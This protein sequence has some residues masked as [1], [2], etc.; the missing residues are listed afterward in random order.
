MFFRQ[1]LASVLHLFGAFLFF[2]GG[3][4][5][6]SLFFSEKTRMQAV[7]KLFGE[8]EVCWMVGVGLLGIAALMVLGFYA[9]HRGKY[10][11]VKGDV[12]VDVR[13][14]EKAVEKCLR[15]KFGE[16]VTL[17][18]V[19]GGRQIE[20]EVEAAEEIIDSC[21]LELGML[22]KGKLGILNPFYLTTRN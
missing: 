18:G 17:V 16:K 22:L 12:E 6:V 4:F 8:P 10:V 5:S 1:A 2:A 9:L 11:R 3:C 20:I 15:E 13:V 7:E 19:K 14:V 21:K